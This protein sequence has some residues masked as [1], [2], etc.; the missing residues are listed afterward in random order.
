MGRLKGL[1]LRMFKNWRDYGPAVAHQFQG[2]VRRS[3]RYLCNLPKSSGV[4][5]Y[6]ARITL[7]SKE[8]KG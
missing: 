6:L 8:E 4:C 2:L 3:F 5:D 7:G 1:G